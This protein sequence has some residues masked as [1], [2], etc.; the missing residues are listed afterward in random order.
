T[1]GGCLPATRRSCSGSS[2]PVF[3]RRRR[4]TRSTPCLVI[5]PAPSASLWWTNT[6]GRGF[7]LT[8]CARKRPSPWLKRFHSCAVNLDFMKQIIFLG[9]LL[10][11]VGCQREAPAPPV[12]AATNQ[13]YSVRG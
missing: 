11:A 12:S 1:A 2:A 8:D 13:T 7:I 9:G 5:S 6:D 10:L 3:W 4:T